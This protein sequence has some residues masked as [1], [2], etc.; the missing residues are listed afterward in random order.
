MKWTPC[1]FTPLNWIS[2]LTTALLLHILPSIRQA[3]SRNK[4]R[5]Q[6]EA[7]ICDGSQPNL[8]CLAVDAGWVFLI[9]GVPRKSF[10]EWVNP[11]CSQMMSRI[12]FLELLS[13][14]FR[15][16]IGQMTIEYPA[17]HIWS[18][19][20]LFLPNSDL[21]NWQLS[22]FPYCVKNNLFNEYFKN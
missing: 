10:V 1:P 20:S 5:D 3:I 17:Q 7:R 9:C 6:N 2:P 11:C 16:N 22:N 21:E 8:F 18:S 4:L 13:T 19:P 15:N 12:L 14:I